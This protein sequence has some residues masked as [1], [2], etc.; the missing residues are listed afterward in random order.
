MNEAN[1]IS[2]Q[3]KLYGFI[4]E[5]AGRSSFSASMNRLFKKNNKDAMTIPMNIREDDFFFTVSNMKKSHVNGAV[6]SNEFVSSVVELLDE[7]S[8]AVLNSGM[9]DILVKEGERLIGDISSIKALIKFLESKDVKKIALI[10]TNHFAKAFS[11]MSKKSSFEISYFSDDLEDL[12]NFTKQMNI[13][14]ADIN[15]MAFKMSTDL[16]GFDS[17]INFSDF[18]NLEMIEK[19]PKLNLDMKQKIEFSALKN[20]AKELGS[21]YLAYD[22]LLNELSQ[23][24]YDFFESKGHFNIES[25]S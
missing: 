4:G 24:A 19:L 17:V 14:N 12:M 3:T 9:C 23:S 8:Q 16:S 1:V 5:Q 15:R 2:K 25:G 22:D 10:G 20:R 18:I 7:P 13:E 21:E 11:F 6:I